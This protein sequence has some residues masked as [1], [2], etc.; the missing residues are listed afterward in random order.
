MYR[1]MVLRIKKKEIGN[2]HHVRVQM[3]VMVMLEKK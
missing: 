3:P 1:E 2:I